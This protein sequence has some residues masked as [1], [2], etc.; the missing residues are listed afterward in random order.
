MDKR[1]DLAEKKVLLQEINEGIIAD[2]IDG[3]DLNKYDKIFFCMVTEV[4]I[5]FA[6]LW[7]YEKSLFTNKN[8]KNNG[9]IKNIIRNINENLGKLLI[10]F[11]MEDLGEINSPYG[12]YSCLEKIK[13]PKKD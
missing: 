12:E 2:K 1:Y 4:D 5:S 10:M 6:A 3:N 9:Q 11:A 8:L 7:L 13:T